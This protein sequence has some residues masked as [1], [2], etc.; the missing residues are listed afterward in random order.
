GGRSRPPP[1][2]APHWR[3]DELPRS[4]PG[5]SPA[6][7]RARQPPPGPRLGGGP[8]RRVPDPGPAAPQRS[9]DMGAPN[10]PQAPNARK[11]PGTAVALLGNAGRPALPRYRYRTARF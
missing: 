7:E 4:S 9:I 2:R 10:G 3:P 11:Q 6:H 5:R 1:V 8:P